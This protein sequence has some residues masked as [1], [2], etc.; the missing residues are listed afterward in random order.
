MSEKTHEHMFED[1]TCSFGDCNLE[2]C[3]WCEFVR[4]KV[5]DG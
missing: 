3:V 2:L 5:S 1:C 4:E